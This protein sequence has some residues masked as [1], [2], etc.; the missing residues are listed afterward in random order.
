MPRRRIV[1]V[2]ERAGG[3]HDDRR[4]VKEG[5]SGAR[6]ERC[7]AGSIAGPEEGGGVTVGAAPRLG[8]RRDAGTRCVA[9]PTAG[10]GAKGTRRTGSAGRGARGWRR[11]GCGGIGGGGRKEASGLSR[12]GNT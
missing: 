8:L 2:A 7:A 3:G 12:V 4:R 11:C 10:Q 6:R 9:E 1:G 5:R